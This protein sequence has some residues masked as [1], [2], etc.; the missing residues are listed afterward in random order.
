MVI[1]VMFEEIEAIKD[2]RENGQLKSLAEAIQEDVGEA[3]EKAIQDTLRGWG[4]HLAKALGYKQVT[5]EQEETG[6]LQITFRKDICEGHTHGK[7]NVMAALK[8]LLHTLKD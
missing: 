1:E 4:K 3:V 5:A 8:D 7:E 6:T 2:L